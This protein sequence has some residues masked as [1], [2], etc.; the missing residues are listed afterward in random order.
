MPPVS[1]RAP[2][3]PQALI[4]V[5]GDNTR[6]A[7][8]VDGQSRDNT[9]NDNPN[10]LRN[11]I[12][13][14]LGNDIH[15]LIEQQLNAQ[16]SSATATLPQLSHLP[17]SSR[18]RNRSVDMRIRT[19]LAHK[20]AI[21]A[22]VDTNLYATSMRDIRVRGAGG[23]HP[24]QEYELTLRTPVTD[25]DGNVR[26]AEQTHS[27]TRAEIA[28]HVLC[29]SGFR[30]ASGTSRDANSGSALRLEELMPPRRLRIARKW[31]ALS[32]V[33]K[34]RVVSML[35]TW[36]TSKKRALKILLPIKLA[37]SLNK[38]K[39][40]RR[41]VNNSIERSDQL[42]IR[43]PNVCRGRV[44]A[45]R[46]AASGRPGENRFS[47]R[48]MT[49]AA[50]PPSSS[51][52][53]TPPTSPR[54]PRSPTPPFSSQSSTP[55]SSPARLSPAGIRSPI[56]T[57]S[58]Q[59][60]QPDSDFFPSAERR[61][62]IYS[63]TAAT[64]DMRA[65]T[66]QLARTHKSRP[67]SGADCNCAWRCAWAMILTQQEPQALAQRLVQLL[68]TNSRR[69]AADIK[70][71]C[72]A[73]HRDGLHVIMS[74]R[75]DAGRFVYRGDGP[76]MEQMLNRV[77]IGVMQKNGIAPATAAAFFDPHRMA[78]AEDIAHFV[79]AMGATSAVMQVESPGNPDLTT[80]ALRP[81][82]DGV[83]E[84]LELSPNEDTIPTAH[85]VQ[86]LATSPIARLV[87]QHFDLLIPDALWRK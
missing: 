41:P 35:H 39:R 27:R 45:T 42:A 17:V 8:Q 38:N 54:S 24:V 40:I 62:N 33:Q 15:R 85:F 81:N 66:A 49:P 20:L 9:R 50:M 26:I 44:I 84:K 55:T 67:I 47:L 58:P 86:A 46:R 16:E 59:A 5:A 51:M 43:R 31:L 23:A 11:T 19:A 56:S 10:N 87:D 65:L 57:P 75:G 73:V 80:L 69:D 22:L 1:F 70:T 34:R 48:E 7:P 3:Y 18:M 76:E 83:I 82:D 78:T 71:I 64:T 13:N 74:G 12:R 36:M 77:A 37:A 30:L 6:R 72:A 53:F 2:V 14:N 21:G 32:D 4:P 63:A 61:A 52:P 79:H 60:S 25:P 68:G 29:E 28:L